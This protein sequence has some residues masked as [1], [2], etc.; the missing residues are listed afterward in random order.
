M[1][2]SQVLYLMK[3][4]IVV[5]WHI[6]S[7]FLCVP[8]AEGQIQL[9]SPDWEVGKGSGSKNV[10]SEISSTGCCSRFPLSATGC[11]W[12]GSARGYTSPP[13]V[14]SSCPLVATGNPFLCEIL[15]TATAVSPFWA[16]WTV[17]A[18][19]QKGKVAFCWGG[20][21]LLRSR[22]APRCERTVLAVLRGVG[23]N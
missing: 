5:T 20:N 16:R 1:F 21:T 23:K 12:C 2:G 6:Q 22:G 19:I 15:L 14:Q 13:R 8:V 11:G 9:P 17:Q 7:L 10:H 3:R 18:E 4:A